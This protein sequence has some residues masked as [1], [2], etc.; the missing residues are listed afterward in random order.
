MPAGDAS[1]LLGRPVPAAVVV[2]PRPV[3]SAADEPLD[4]TAGPAKALE[5][6][7]R[8]EDAPR[9]EVLPPQ[10]GYVWEFYVSGMLLTFLVRSVEEAREASAILSPLL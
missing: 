8:P 3:G 7:G 2:M 6:L 9:Y 10:N 5:V 1:G 4:H